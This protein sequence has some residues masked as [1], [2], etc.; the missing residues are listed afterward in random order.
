MTQSQLLGTQ[1]RKSG[2]FICLYKPQPNNNKRL[3]FLWYDPKIGCVRR[4][5]I[6]FLN[7]VILY[8]MNKQKAIG[9]KGKICF[10]TPLEETKEIYYCVII[11]EIILW[12]TDDKSVVNVVVHKSKVH[13]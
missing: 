5:A 8:Y 10:T 7:S 11:K 9:P 12:E 4:Q 6:Y 1:K 13:I 2:L 3:R